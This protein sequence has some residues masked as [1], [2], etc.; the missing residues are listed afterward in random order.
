MFFTA[1]YCLT[2]KG[3]FKPAEIE[4]NTVLVVERKYP[5][6]LRNK[7][8]LVYNAKSFTKLTFNNGLFISCDK[9]YINTISIEEI[10]IGS[11]IEL[12]T[13]LIW[14]GSSKLYVPSKTD[15]SK[16]KI[17]GITNKVLPEHEFYEQLGV[18]FYKRISNIPVMEKD[19]F[20]L[21]DLLKV[22][23]ENLKSFVTGLFSQ[24]KYI[25]I[26]N[27]DY[28]GVEKI[29]CLI[30]PSVGYCVL[31][32]NN[33]L[34]LSDNDFVIVTN[35]SE[36]YQESYYDF[37]CNK[38]LSNGIVVSEKGGGFAQQFNSKC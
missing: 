28:Y 6:V 34:I 16:I 21:K 19:N 10:E 5:I 37:K 30:A 32:E 29:V 12:Q 20:E 15:L 23:S 38:I 3:F 7:P 8:E 25:E 14:N 31:F 13:N 35:K 33:S 27:K 1:D 18:N 36:E 22:G 4:N 9:G 24:S 2:Q 26:K 11:K 17:K